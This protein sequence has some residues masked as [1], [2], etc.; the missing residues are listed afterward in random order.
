MRRSGKVIRKLVWWAV[1]ALYHR[2]E[3]R[4]APNLSASGPQLAN[5]SHF[6]GFTDPLLLIY[7]MDRVPRFVA[8]DV[9]WNYPVAKSL[10]KW[11]R[12]IPVH[13]ADDAGPASND[14]MFA[15]TYEA[16]GDGDLI[17][18]FPEGITVDDPSIARIK[19]GSAR[20]VLGARAA[21]VTGI[22]LLSAGIH[23]E[24]KAALRS[25][26][27]VDIGWA[28]DLDDFVQESVAPGEPEDASNR[29][30]VRALTDLME[31]NLR[32][33]A[34]DFE[35]WA[36]ARLLSSASEVALR[37]DAQADGIGVGHG[38][39]E[40]LARLLGDAP[41]Q[42]RLAVSEAMDKYQADLDAMGFDDEMLMT[43]L[44]K[45]SAFMTY[46]I[47]SIIISLVLL[48]FAFAGAIVNAIPMT[49]VWLIGRLRVAD[50]MMAT[51]KPIGAVLA[52]VVTWS[53]WAW[54]GWSAAGA[55]GLASV[56][57]LLPVLLF[58]LIGI[59]ERGVLVVGAIRGFSH[60]RS[61]ADVYGQVQDHRRAVVEAVARAA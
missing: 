37:T 31:A 30:L 29:A 13:K 19:T 54:F 48:P 20:I 49:I 18:I 40:R 8:R 45:A 61:F 23:Y 51:V 50:A 44:N 26:V 56:L 57:L 60:S 46:L 41:E 21:G 33:A 17:T 52:F 2:V 16:L 27:F 25:E 32:E 38:D 47:S 9:I 59:V 58:A 5:S 22:K 4:Q 12:A 42:D 35:S 1:A 7:T 28:I 3:V 55:S 24:N 15:S 36:V 6:G 34:P 14:T 11:A 10:M 43:G 39:R 53:F